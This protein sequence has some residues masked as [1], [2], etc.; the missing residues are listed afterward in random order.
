MNGIE[1][2]S[3]STES[4]FLVVPFLLITIFTMF[5]FVVIDLC[6][7]GDVDFVV[8]PACL[9]LVFGACIYGLIFHEIFPTEYNTYKVTISE[10]VSMTEFYEKYEI[11]DVDGQIYTVRER[12]SE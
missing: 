4:E 12:D 8:I 2:L 7:H 5:A 10:N 1:I 3:T 9:G 6:E 11:L